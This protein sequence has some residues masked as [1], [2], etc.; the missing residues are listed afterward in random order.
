[1]VGHQS[2]AVVHGLEER[3]L[4]GIRPARLGRTGGRFLVIEE[5]D[6]VFR[7]VFVGQVFRRGPP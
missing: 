7:Q 1:M 4:V 2:L 5:Q 3:R 6:V